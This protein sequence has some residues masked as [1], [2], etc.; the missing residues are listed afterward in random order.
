MDG[1]TMNLLLVQWAIE[2]RRELIREKIRAR[3]KGTKMQGVRIEHSIYQVLL[4]VK[5]SQAK[6][7]RTS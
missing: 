7:A 1:T 5:A 6:N 2:K 4:S 3:I